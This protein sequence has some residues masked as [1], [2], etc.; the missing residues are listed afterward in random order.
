MNRER[1][2]T[3]A[4]IMI[5][6]AILGILV[7]IVVPRLTGRTQEAQLQTTR[8]QIENISTALDAFEYDNGRYPSSQ[9]GLQALREAPSGL[10]N[11]KGP[12]L[13]K[14]VPLDPWRNPYLYVSPGLKNKDFDLYS[15]GKDGQEGTEDDI[16]NW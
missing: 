5:V 2:F 12:Y 10:P 8:L 3:L 7:S 11:W 14:S 4:E 9:E 6:V 13:K 16:G 15:L 1:G